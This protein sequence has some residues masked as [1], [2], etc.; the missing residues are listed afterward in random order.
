MNVSKGVVN[1]AAAAA[2]WLA[3]FASEAAQSPSSRAGPGD[4]GQGG[5]AR[6]REAHAQSDGC[7]CELTLRVEDG[8]DGAGDSVPVRLTIRN[9]GK[10]AIYWLRNRFSSNSLWAVR[11]AA[12]NLIAPA[13]DTAVADDPTLKVK[14]AS[15][16][17]VT[18][19]AGEEFSH[20]TRL[21]RLPPGEHA[22]EGRAVIYLSDFKTKA[23]LTSAPVKVRVGRGR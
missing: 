8:W 1:A 12:G 22:L 21:G 5:A 16:T 2:L 13:D 23:E 14:E 11:D 20:S 3:G 15:Y 4:A 18:I 17:R 9:K 10:G 6:P 7:A 19:E